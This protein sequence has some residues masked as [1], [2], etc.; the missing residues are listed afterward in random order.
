MKQT[1][2]VPIG[3]AHKGMIYHDFDKTPHL[4]GGGTTRYGKTNLIKSILTTLILNNPQHLKLHLIDLKAGVEF[5]RFEN[6][7]QV[8]GRVATSP[9]ETYQL[10]HNV[11]NHLDAKKTHFRNNHYSNIVD[12]NIKTRHFIIIDEAGDL[13]PETFM[14]KEEK[15]L[16]QECQWMLAHLARIGGAFG[17]RVLFFSQYTTS[18]VLPRQIKQNADAKIA[19]KMQNDYSSEV[20]LGEGFTQAADLPKIPGRAIFKDGPDIYELQ[21]PLITDDKMNKLLKGEFISE[22]QPEANGNTQFDL[23]IRNL[24]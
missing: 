17:F 16:H 1:W 13:V 9:H 3:Q 4:I 15:K 11:L 8:S 12:T 20:V 22:S 18:D 10:L 2:R 19:F 14:S 7:R 24:D 5:S 6:L 21:V 23:E